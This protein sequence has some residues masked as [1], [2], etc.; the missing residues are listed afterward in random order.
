MRRVRQTSAGL[1]PATFSRL[2]AAVALSAALHVFLIY[3]LSLPA[4]SG[5][6]AQV[7][8]FHA[9]LMSPES[10]R[11]P[12]R[13]NPPE[14]ISARQPP[15]SPAFVSKPAAT[16]FADPSTL[17]SPAVAPIDPQPAAVAGSDVSVSTIPD[18]VHYPAK[19][20]DIFPQVLRRITPDYPQPA[21]DA[22]VAGSVTL[23]VLIDAAGR[24]A[25][26]SVMDASPEG[27]FEQAA[28]QALENTVFYPAQKDGRIVGSRIL[29]KVEFDPV[30]MQAAQ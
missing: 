13:A 8:V 5:A 24:V 20:L 19:D 30:E 1:S 21:R 4:G 25:G 18:L 3:G 15:S 28:T 9:R 17:P 10:L 14:R 12:Q 22:Q 29:I 2:S 7:S 6:G 27:V 26:L 16:V 11:R 23:L